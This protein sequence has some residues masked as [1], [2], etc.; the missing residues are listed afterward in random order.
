MNLY[1]ILEAPQ[2]C[3]FNRG[4]NIFPAP[5]Q[6]TSATDA[7]ET[8]PMEV[9]LSTW[10]AT[11]GGN[12]MLQQVNTVYRKQNCRRRTVPIHTGYYTVDLE[13]VL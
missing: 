9:W 1:C 12:W 6:E 8:A 5:L 10:L 7:V 13:T 4:S 11:F 3:F 2:F